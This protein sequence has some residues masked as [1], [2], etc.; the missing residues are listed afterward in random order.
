MVSTRI[1][2]VLRLAL[3]FAVIAPLAAQA[4]NNSDVAPLAKAP[5]VPPPIVQGCSGSVNDDCADAIAITSAPFTDTR[6]TTCTG[7]EAGEPGSTCTSQ[8]NS[9]WYTYSNP[10]EFAQ[11]VSISLEGSDFDTAIMIWSGTC[12]AFTPVACNDDAIG[13]QSVVSFVADPG[14]VYYIQVGGFAGDTGNLVFNLTAEGGRCA[15]TDI[16]GVL[17]SGSPDYPSVSGDQTGRLNRN[18]IGSSCATPKTC[19]IF[20]AT[21]PRPFDAYTIPNDSENDV[22]VSVSLEVLDQAGCNLQSNLYLD[23]FDPANICTDYLG[24]PGLSSGSPPTP[25][26]FTSVVPAGQSAVVVV[27]SVDI[28]AGTG[29]NYR[30]LVLGDICRVNRDWVEIPALN[31]YGLGALALLLAGAGIALMRRS[32]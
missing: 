12:G 21:D 19:N 23:A 22:C 29:C 27:H 5:F 4:A 14:V 9:I 32:G 8:A 15:P 18:G 25:T 20:T 16:T 6:D 30:L 24:D 10:A 26:N 2:A 28:A 3:S 31:T 13:F 11:I 7:D 17:G 1:Q